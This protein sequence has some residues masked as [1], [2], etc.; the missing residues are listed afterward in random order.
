MVR[1]SMFELLDHGKEARLQW[2]QQGCQINVDNLSNIRREASG[3]FRKK[4]RGNI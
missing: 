4:K 3:H 1:L 2:L